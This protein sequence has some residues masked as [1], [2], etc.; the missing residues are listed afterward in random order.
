MRNEVETHLYLACKIIRDQNELISAYRDQ[1]KNVETEKQQY[2]QKLDTVAKD[3]ENLRVGYENERLERL[4]DAKRLEEKLELQREY[5][6]QVNDELRLQ[7]MGI[8][9]KTDPSKNHMIENHSSAAVSPMFLRKETDKESKSQSHESSPVSSLL[10]LIPR[11]VLHKAEFIW[12][13]NG[14]SRKLRKI[15]SGAQGDPYI[16]DPFTTGPFGYRLTLWVYL[17][18]RG[19]GLGSYVSVY[20]RVTAGEFDPVL[21]WPIKPVYSFMLLDQSP[22][23][24][25]RQHHV[26]VRDLTTKH[27]G[28]DRP[29]KEEKS[30]IV[31]FDDFIIHEELEKRNFLVED[32]I[33]VKIVAEIPEFY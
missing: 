25:K 33:F 26:R 27:G 9:G 28:I 29:K 8:R 17:N 3:L 14:F 16:S 18:G 5:Q 13:I 10:S 1:L 21:I 19:K 4:R 24:A 22:E 32:S 30:V 2:S 6:A 31:G 12:R 20:V 11:N 23:N 15:Q 7:I